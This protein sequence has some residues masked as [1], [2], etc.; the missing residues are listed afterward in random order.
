MSNVAMLNFSY[1]VP[2]KLLSSHVLLMS[3][4]LCLP[5][6]GRLVHFFVL[7]RPA[8]P[9]ELPPLFGRRQWGNYGAVAIRTALVI[10]FCGYMFYQAYDAQAT[11]GDRA[12][13]SPLYG[14]WNVEEFTIDGEQRPALIT[15]QTRWRRLVFDRPRLIG[16]QLMSDARKRYGLQLDEGSRTMTLSKF[17]QPAFKATL[18]YQHLDADVLNLEGTFDGQPVLAK[19]RRQDASNF[20][21]LSRGFHWINEY[22]F[23]R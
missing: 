17:D 4:F 16:I 13:K 3:M 9:A 7:N 22:P 15:D 5:D 18:T 12:P 19:L 8:A 10:A 21:L 14:I 11:Y 23:N 20:L 2:V 1:D 6:L